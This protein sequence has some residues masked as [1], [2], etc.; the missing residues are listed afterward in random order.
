MRWAKKPIKKEPP[1]GA[2]RWVIYFTWRPTEA[3]DGYIYWL[4]NIWVRQV[5]S[6]YLT[7][8]VGY[9]EESTWVRPDKHAVTI[10]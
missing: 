5:Y 9:A 7:K 8:W 1:D 10:G 6:S 4:E 3:E 2:K